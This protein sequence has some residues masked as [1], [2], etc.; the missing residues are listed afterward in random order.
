MTTSTSP[1][2]VIPRK[3]LPPV[4]YPL[5][6][7]LA[8]VVSGAL[9]IE[10]SGVS[11][12]SGY[13]AMIRGAFGSANNVSETLIRTTPL[14]LIGLGI[15]VGMK[16]RLFNIG[17][18][19][20]LYIGALGATFCGLFLGPLPAV[21]GIP[22]SLLAGFVGGGLWAGIAGF[23]RLR[24]RANEVIV[25]L[26]LNYVAIQI[27]HY[28]ISGPWRDPRAT[29]PFTAEM[30]QGVR[31]PVLLPGTRLHAGILIALVVAFVL[32][33][34]LRNTVFGYELMVTGAN[35]E[36]ARYGGMRSKHVLM[37]A[38]VLSGGLAGL[39]GAI[40]VTGLHH[41]L[42]EGLSPGYGYTAIAI[43]MLGKENPLGVVFAAFLFAS[44]TV[45]ADGMQR[46]T[47]VPVSIVMLIEGLVLLFVLASEFLRVRRIQELRK[48]ESG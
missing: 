21:V 13:S 12:L 24:F 3:G 23:L 32:W 40:E 36:A 11:W 29:E 17:A 2:S 42:L 47:G 26:M 4:V 46:S 5:L 6:A 25:T 15:A 37:T 43:A 7:V 45:G 44:L 38:M 19:G 33:W 1:V 14:L 8:A 16:G 10:L 31:L 41:R 28:L 27:M 39:A 48:W 18:E 35:D 9:L 34:V 20:Q 30:V 22:L